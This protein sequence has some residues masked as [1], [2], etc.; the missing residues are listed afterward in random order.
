MLNQSKWNRQDW[1]LVLLWLILNLLIALTMDL[2]LFTQTTESMKYSGIL[3]KLLTTEFWASVEWLFVIPAQRIGFLFL[4]GPQL[5]LSSYLFNFIA[6]LWANTFWL[7][8]ETTM[9]D[10]IAMAILLFGMAVSK[11]T[12]FG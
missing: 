12:L 10:Y 11:F 3:A 9:D 5:A 4:S 1:Y 2:A 7:N 6:Q 8:L